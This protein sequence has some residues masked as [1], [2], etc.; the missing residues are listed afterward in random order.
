MKLPL[1]LFALM[2]AAATAAQALDA[3]CEPFVAAAEKT[4]AQPARH[5][6][7]Q[8][9]ATTRAEAI[10]I[11]GK[12]YMQMAGR[13]MKGPPNFAATEKKLNAAMR[14]GE[15]QLLDCQKLG[16]E[17]VDGIAT[18][19][20]RYRMKM[21]GTTLGSE[22]PAKVFIGDDGLLYAQDSGDGAKVRYRYQGVTAP[23][24]GP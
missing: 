9:D 2:L 1:C 11:G 15:I 4:A 6:V 3:A 10:L 21:P 19:V 18:T 12:I 17:T 8:L 5:S 16:R 14:S 7:S 22:T 23:K 20:Y 13:W 24:V